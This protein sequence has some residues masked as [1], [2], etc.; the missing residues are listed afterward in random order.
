MFADRGAI[1]GTQ[2]TVAGTNCCAR[3]DGEELNAGAREVRIL[4][5]AVCATA[6]NATADTT[7]IGMIPLPAAQLG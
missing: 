4:G 7:R 2:Q 6:A 3:T 5:P 1:N